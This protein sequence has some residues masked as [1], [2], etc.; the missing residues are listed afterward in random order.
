MK[1]IDILN[2]FVR[3]ELS[4][5]RIGLTPKS[6]IKQTGCDYS[7]A[8]VYGAFRRFITEGVAEGYRV[9]RIRHFRWL[10]KESP[11]SEPEITHDDDEKLEEELVSTYLTDI[12]FED[13]PD[14]DAEFRQ[15]NMNVVA[16]PVNKTAETFIE[17]H[18]ANLR[19]SVINGENLLVTSENETFEIGKEEG[20]KMKYCDWIINAKHPNYSNNKQAYV[21]K[22]VITY[23][24]VK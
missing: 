7:E 23:K 3:D 13:N 17:K 18:G 24:K 8:Q 14:P 19:I 6:F 4:S 5:S 15:V 12:E 2:N 10:K 20:A 1:K 11:I 9:G 16:K 21:G 22:N